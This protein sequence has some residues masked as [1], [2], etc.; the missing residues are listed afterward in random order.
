VR[1]DVHGC[2]LELSVD[3]PLLTSDIGWLLGSFDGKTAAGPT[4]RARLEVVS[5]EAFDSAPPLG[6]EMLAQGAE[7]GGVG[8]P[9]TVFREPGHRVVV[10]D[11]RAR[12]S[13]D[14]HGREATLQ[15]CDPASLTPEQRTSVVFFAVSELLRHHGLFAIHAAALERDGVSALIVG[16]PGA[17]KTTA[18]LSLLRHGWRLLSDDHPL[19]RD[20]GAAGLEVLPF[21]VPARLTAATI[22]RFPEIDRVVPRPAAGAKATVALDTIASHGI[23]RP[24]RPVAVLLPEI[25][26]QP[27]TR[28][29]VMPRGQALEEVLGITLGLAASERSV[30]RQ[31]F[32][33]LSRLVRETPCYRLTSGAHVERDLPS[34]IGRLLEAVA[35]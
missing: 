15:V 29:T 16:R 3:D 14:E 18:M 8:W 25:V 6:G 17:G 1:F 5:P 10:W 35:A 13:L 34:A 27:D 7:A 23:G 30:A 20:A 33:L 11:Q 32:A 28:L 22:A 24:A 26:N 21:A 19:L 9:W 4:A 12:L 31:H 2:L